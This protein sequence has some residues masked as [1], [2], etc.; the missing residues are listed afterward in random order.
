MRNQYKIEDKDSLSNLLLSPRAHVKDEAYITCDAC[1]CHILYNTGDKPPK[2]AIRNWWLVGEIPKSV[3][4]DDIGDILAASVAKV[5]IFAN[6]YPY[7]AGAHKTIKG[8]HV[9]FI[10]DPEHAGYVLNTC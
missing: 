10:H 9:F 6:V 1:Y 7:S 3:V 2:F 8:H 4:G 5:R